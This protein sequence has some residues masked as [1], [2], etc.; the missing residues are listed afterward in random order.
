MRAISAVGFVENAMTMTARV[1]GFVS[2]GFEMSAPNSSGT[3]T[4]RGEIGAV[5]AYWRGEKVVDLWGGHR[6]PDSDAPW[7][8]DTMVVVMSMRT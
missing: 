4:E 1:D 5:A 8:R 7:N 3:I 6:S 2:S